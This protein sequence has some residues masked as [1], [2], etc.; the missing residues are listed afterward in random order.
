MNT[1]Q[2]TLFALVAGSMVAAGA[3]AAVTYGNGM[4]AEPYIG[5][6]IGQYDADGADDAAISYGVYGGAKFTPNFGAEAEYLTT[7]KESANKQLNSEYEGKV[8]GLYATYEYPFAS[9]GGLYAK[10]RL[11]FAKNEI[12]VSY[13]GTTAKLATD[14]TGIAGGVGLGYNLSPNAAVEVAYDLYPTISNNN[15]DTDVS[16]VTLGAKF[17]F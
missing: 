13:P 12:E 9:T 16:G 17:K 3:Q 1:V 7:S 11:G 2:K 14:D 15:G 6:K 10:G 8:Y 5:A 4:T